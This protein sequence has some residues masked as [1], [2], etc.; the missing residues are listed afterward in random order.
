MPALTRNRRFAREGHHVRT[1]RS[2]R[3]DGLQK[4]RR[5]KRDGARAFLPDGVPYVQA[6]GVFVGP[7]RVGLAA[8]PF[9]KEHS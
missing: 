5:G 7:A 9:R 4:N 8:R 1:S 2:T 6:Q 3:R